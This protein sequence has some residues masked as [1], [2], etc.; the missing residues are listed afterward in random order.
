LLIQ[1][2]LNINRYQCEVIFITK[3]IA[4]LDDLVDMKSIDNSNMYWYFQN[5]AK[6]S[7]NSYIITEETYVPSASKIKNIVS[8]GMGGSGLTPLVIGSLFK[9]DLLYPFIISQDYEIPKFVNKNTFFIAI[10][11]SGE[12]EEVISQYYKAK[13]VNAKLFIIAQGSRLIEIAKSDHTPF[14]QYSTKVPSRASFAFM[15]GSSLACLKNIKAITI[16]AQSELKE[17]ITAIIQMEKKIGPHIG[18]VDNTAKKIAIALDQFTPIIYTEPPFTSL[19]AIF[20]KML[21]ENAKEFA[22]YNNIPEM[23]HNE[24]MSWS[25]KNMNKKF[26]PIFIRDDKR[27]SSLEKEIDEIKKLFPSNNLYEL[28]PI[29]RSK[30][31]RFYSLFYLMCM[32]SYYRAILKNKDPSLTLELKKLKENLRENKILPIN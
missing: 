5:L 18:I 31:A 15:F 10:S 22:F 25:S 28:R 26:C 4:A 23:R 14:F 2:Y 7:L 1:V 27:L 3:K 32:I 12:T 20:S 9:Q 6:D 13:K 30:L 17:S 16:D 19:G 11:D 8:G 24:I 29:G 21:N